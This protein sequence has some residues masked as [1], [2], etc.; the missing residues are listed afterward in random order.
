[1]RL[2]AREVGSPTPLYPF[3]TLQG[4]I[5]PVSIVMLQVDTGATFGMTTRPWPP[6]SLEVS[7]LSKRKEALYSSRVPWRPFVLVPGPEADG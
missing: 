2:F 6:A 1:M 4:N 3:R 7:I 5:G